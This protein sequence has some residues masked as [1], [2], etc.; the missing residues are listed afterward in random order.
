MIL[1]P[2]A[3][4]P[5]CVCF[6]SRSETNEERNKQWQAPSMCK[7]CIYTNKEFRNTVR[8]AI[9][10]VRTHGSSCG[11]RLYPAFVTKGLKSNRIRTKKSIKVHVACMKLSNY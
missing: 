11:C 1:V 4:K 7:I 10:S 9:V 6:I 8:M 2:I 3:S 5:L